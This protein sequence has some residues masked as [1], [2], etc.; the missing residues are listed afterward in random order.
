M[1]KRARGFELTELLIVV[2]ILLILA[3]LIAPN[4]II[5]I[6]KSKQENI[7][8]DTTVISTSI[9]DKIKTD[10]RTFNK[11]IQGIMGVNKTEKELAK[12]IGVLN[13]H[14]TKTWRIKPWERNVLNF[15]NS[16]LREKKAGME[17]LNVKKN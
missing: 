7:T 9:I 2:A 3:S 15:N 13:E 12:S 17:V 11:Y 4:I 8:K 14:L 6:Q 1:L 10:H 16:G 5:S